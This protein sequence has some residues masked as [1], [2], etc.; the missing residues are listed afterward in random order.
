MTATL[1][2]PSAHSHAGIVIN[3]EATTLGQV[4]SAGGPS[5]ALFQHTNA[6]H[7]NA[8]AFLTTQD[9]H[10]GTGSGGATGGGN[11]AGGGNGGG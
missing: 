11:G 9:D 7:S 4:L 10:S 2:N 6:K 8:A 3:L 5:S 1:M